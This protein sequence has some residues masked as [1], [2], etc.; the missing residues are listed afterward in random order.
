MAET[1]TKD[2]QVTWLKWKYAMPK[3]RGSYKGGSSTS[4]KHAIKR[5]KV[6][7]GPSPIEHVKVITA[8]GGVRWETRPREKR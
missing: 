2:G 3:T 5:K 1:K 8:D 4:G 6:G 7:G